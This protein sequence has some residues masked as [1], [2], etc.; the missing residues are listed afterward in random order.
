MLM[1]WHIKKEKS[2]DPAMAGKSGVLKYLV[3]QTDGE[4]RAGHVA[5]SCAVLNM[6]GMGSQS[7][8]TATDYGKQCVFPQDLGFVGCTQT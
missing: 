2:H 7:C 6:V 5:R 8:C 1:E 3:L 4:L